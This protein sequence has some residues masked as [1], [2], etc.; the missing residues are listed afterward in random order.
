MTADIR[1]GMVAYLAQTHAIIHDFGFK[2]KSASKIKYYVNR[3][4]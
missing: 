2:G 4:G 1:F 3:I